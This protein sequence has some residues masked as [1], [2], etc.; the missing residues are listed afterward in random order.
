MWARSLQDALCGH[1]VKPMQPP[2]TCQKQW[3][4]T[5]GSAFNVSGWMVGAVPVEDLFCNMLLPFTTGHM[6]RFHNSYGQGLLQQ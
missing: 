3:L 1:F 5:S 4:L 6:S 2:N